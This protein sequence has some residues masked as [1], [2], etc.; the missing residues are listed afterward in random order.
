MPSHPHFLWTDIFKTRNAKSATLIDA[1][2]ENVLFKTLT[3]REVRYLSR[4]VYE[5]VYL[6]E[7]P[8]FHQNDRGLG[9]YV[10]GKGRVA[11]KTLQPEG[12]FH[13]TTL[14]EKSFFGEL[15]LVDGNNI[16]TASAVALERSVLIGFFKPDLMEILERKPA[17]GVKILYQLATVL[18]ERLLETTDRITLLSRARQELHFNEEVI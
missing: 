12:E 4:L 3:T 1:L 18:G 7:E 17:M 14:H 16:R 15:A 2:R 6:P 13:V 9:M 8:I 5:R 11:I 10:I